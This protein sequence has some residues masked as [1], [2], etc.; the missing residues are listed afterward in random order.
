MRDV[1]TAG[2]QRRSSPDGAAFCLGYVRPGLQPEVVAYR[3][4]GSDEAG[5][6]A[7]VVDVPGDDV[8]D[9]DDVELD[10]EDDGD[11][12]DASYGGDED[13]VP[14]SQLDSTPADP[15]PRGD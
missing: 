3:G 8:E 7:A 9:E 4:G 6:L 5:G 2:K 14:A 10:E 15:E 11:E 13:A 1:L 12:P